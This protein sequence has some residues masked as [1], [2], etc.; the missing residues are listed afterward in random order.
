MDAPPALIIQR[1][2]PE[3]QRLWDELGFDPRP[4]D[5]LIEQSGLTARAVSAMLLMLELKG[6][7]EAHPGGAFSRKQ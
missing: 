4:V 1:F 2:D 6:V 7:V 3:Y 5:R